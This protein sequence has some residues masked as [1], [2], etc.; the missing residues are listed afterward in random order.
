MLPTA[1]KLFSVEWNPSIA[2]TAVQNH[3]L[4]A[5]THFV[6]PDLSDVFSDDD[7]V[8]FVSTVPDPNQ[9][10]HTVAT[11]QHETAESLLTSLSDVEPGSNILLVGGNNRGPNTLSSIDA[12][13]ILANEK[14]NSI[15]G[16]ANPNDPKSL[17]AL[18]QKLESGMSGFITQPLL[19]SCAKDTLQLYRDCATATTTTTTT[20]VTIL[21]GLAFPKT[22]RGLRFWAKLLGQEE[23]LETDPLFQSHLA[24]FSQPY[25]TP[26]AWVG[27][28]LQD[29]L[30]VGNN[31]NNTANNSCID[32]IHFMPLKNTEDL[33]TI[34]QSLNHAHRSS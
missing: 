29:L 6:F 21:A 11:C 2:A 31:N 14:E 20:D 5:A 27:R 8:Q 15:W 19:S 16:V 10:I 24:Y 18:K 26:I 12:A 13:R 33:C 34:F 25:V 1:T 9:R 32:G 22:I 4:P 7:R 28:E 17:D 23:E 3:L 30:L